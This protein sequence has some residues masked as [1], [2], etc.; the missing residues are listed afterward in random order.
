MDSFSFRVCYIQNTS[1]LFLSQNRDITK[2]RGGELQVE[3]KE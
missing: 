1:Y 2:G 3:G